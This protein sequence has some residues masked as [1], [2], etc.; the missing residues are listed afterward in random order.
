[1]MQH[2]RWHGTP[3]GPMSPVKPVAPI[4]PVNQQVEKTVS[5]VEIATIQHINLTGEAM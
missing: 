4:D 5:Y 1:M 3:V 2:I